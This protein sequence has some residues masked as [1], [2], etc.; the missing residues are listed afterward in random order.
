M[1]KQSE[2]YTMIGYDHHFTRAGSNYYPS[3]SINYCL[4][5]CKNAGTSLLT[6]RVKRGQIVL[7]DYSEK[8]RRGLLLLTIQMDKAINPGGLIIFVDY[9]NHSGG[10]YCRKQISV[11]SGNVQAPLGG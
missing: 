11:V 3:S 7:F 4:D 5:T 10:S 1:F 6:R 2:D 9:R 8:S